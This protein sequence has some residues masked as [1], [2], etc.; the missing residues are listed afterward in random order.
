MEHDMPR[1]LPRTPAYVPAARGHIRG[2]RRIQHGTLGLIYLACALAP[3]FLALQR[4]PSPDLAVLLYAALAVWAELL[5]VPPAYA[6]WPSPLLPLLTLILLDG[7][8][9]YVLPTALLALGVRSVRRRLVQRDRWPWPVLLYEAG[10]WLLATAGG[11]AGAEAV[12]ATWRGGPW[13]GVLADSAYGVPGLLLTAL[14]WS[15]TLALAC[16][17]AGLLSAHMAGYRRQDLALPARLGRSMIRALV[18]ALLVYTVVGV[19]MAF[20]GPQGEYIVIVA[21]AGTLMALWRQARGRQRRQAMLIGLAELAEAKDATTGTHLVAVADRTTRVAAAL[22]LPAAAV[23]AYANGALLHDVGKLAVPTSI[24]TKPGRLDDAEWT[25]M[26]SHTTTG[27]ALLRVLPSCATAAL[28]AGH[29]HERWDGSGYPDGL[30]GEAIP[31]AARIVAVVDA[32]DAM[33][34]ER[35]YHCGIPA[36]EARAELRRQRG[37]QFDPAVV[38]AF[39]RAGAGPERLPLWRFFPLSDY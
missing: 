38:D 3:A 34:A 7:G 31:L 36:E 20:L 33:T 15:L 18:C 25:E 17:L 21:V 32:Y 11:V 19:C 6:G 30:A 23:D 28:I 22:G 12:D 29:H 24:L 26:R 35:P 5:V 4:M 9:P 14:A 13:R 16:L 2:T 10:T 1:S 27:R 39:E 8:P 37:R